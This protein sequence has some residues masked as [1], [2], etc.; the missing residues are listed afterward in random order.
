M[1]LL[2]S[3]P[4]ANGC[5]NGTMRASYPS[6]CVTDYFHRTRFR[7]LPSPFQ[8][9]SPVSPM[10]YREIESLA[11]GHFVSP[12]RREREKRRNSRLLGGVPRGGSLQ[13]K[14]RKGE[15]EGKKRVSA[16]E[17]HPMNRLPVGRA[18]CIRGLRSSFVTNRGREESERRARMQ[19][20]R[21]VYFSLSKIQPPL[22]RALG[23]RAWMR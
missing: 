4:L 11:C 6:H 1:Q 19:K 20:P 13:K 9:S 14:G 22:V 16:L 3:L 18:E 15:E 5:V 7:F 10:I 2:I 12:R 8:L 21:R 17:W 23:T